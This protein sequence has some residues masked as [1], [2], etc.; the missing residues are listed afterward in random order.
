MEGILE[1]YLHYS[2]EER[3]AMDSSIEDHRVEVLLII[4]DV[5]FHQ[6]SNRSPA[7]DSSIEDHWRMEYVKVKSK[8]DALQ[9]EWKVV[10]TFLRRSLL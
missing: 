7:I 8:L 4:T 5:F 2:F 3:P 1:H 10:Q 9:K 6:I